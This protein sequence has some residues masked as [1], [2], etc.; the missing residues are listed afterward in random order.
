MT[1][2]PSFSRHL[3]VMAIVNR[4]PDS[5]YDK[6]K[7]FGLAAAVASGAAA[8]AAGA[9]FVDV[10]GVKFAPG[11]PIA[12]EEE[13]DRVVPVVR[14]LAALGAVSVDTVH[15]EVARAALAAGAS[16]INDTTG[17]RDRAMAEMVADSDAAIVIAHSL[18]EPRQQHPLPH[19]DDVA[20][21]VAAFLRQRVELALARGIPPERIIIDPGHDLNKNT[22]QTLELTRR[23]DEIAALG[24]PLLVALSNKDFIGESLGRAR[25]ER[26]AGSLAAAVFSVLHGARIVR[27][28]NVPETVDALR[29]IEAILGWRVPGDLVHNMRAEGND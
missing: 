15:P 12:I 9:E 4:T 24:Y 28:H 1:A 8:F 5:F 20:S 10:G 23:L 29:M 14:E 21:E 7:T 3:A 18:A 22:L 13:I 6:G 19:Y 11:P 27:A 25:D 16:I 2:L 26:V 17:L